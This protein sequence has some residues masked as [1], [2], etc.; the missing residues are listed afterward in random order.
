[1]LSI[2]ST[3]RLSPSGFCRQ[4]LKLLCRLQS[5]H[6]TQSSKSTSKLSSSV[7]STSSNSSNTDESEGASKS[8]RDPLDRDELV[9]NVVSS[10]TLTIMKYLPSDAQLY[11]QLA[12]FDKP[13][14]TMLLLWPCMWS[15]ALAS[16]SSIIRESAAVTSLSSASTSFAS[17][18]SVA[19]DPKLLMLFATGS[20]LMRGAGCTI[21]DMWD[22]KYDKKVARTATRPL[23]SGALS[24]KQAAAFLGLQLTGGLGVLLSFPQEHLQYCFL[25][26][27]ASL[28][29]VG[30]YP[31]MKRYT[32]WPQLVLG[33]T[34]NWGAL[35]GWA[36][37]HGSLDVYD[38]LSVV[39]PLY[40]GGVAWTLV[41]DTLYAHQDKQD[42]VKLGLKSTALYF[43][44]NTKPILVG[45]SALATG[46]WIAAGYNVGYME[47]YYYLGCGAAGAH[48]LWQ[49]GTADLENPKNLAERFKSNATVGA[50]MFASCI[51]GNIGEL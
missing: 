46:S 48:L 47:P 14:G 13:I 42:D 31:L 26:G 43:A 22:A 15:T 18:S 17:L 39:L 9:D 45:F 4:N 19:G 5:Y 20:F 24:Y 7:G 34:F 29:L 32:N 16:G 10:S 40:G 11:A 8:K 36:A 27:A 38:G 50:I 25:L 2:K 37:T 12:R 1:M 51:A 33:M 23:A 35:M 21:N 44:D 41:Y 3:I 30:I 28:P 49:V 6:R